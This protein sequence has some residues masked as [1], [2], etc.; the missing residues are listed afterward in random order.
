MP[1][2]CPKKYQ[3]KAEFFSLQDK[4]TIN[5]WYIN[6]TWTMSQSSTMKKIASSYFFYQMHA[7]Q[8][9]P[10]KSLSTNRQLLEAADELL[11]NFFWISKE[12]HSISRG[13]LVKLVICVY[14]GHP[15]IKITNFMK[16]AIFNWFLPWHTILLVK[17]WFGNLIALLTN[18]LW[19]FHVPRRHRK[20]LNS[21]FG[22]KKY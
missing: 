18:I 6:R 1:N 5:L 12:G 19:D 16:Y 10:Q 8:K 14:S 13:I 22:Q 3:Q 15:K 21:T 2:T 4:H 11:S 20:K 9:C 17:N 7:S